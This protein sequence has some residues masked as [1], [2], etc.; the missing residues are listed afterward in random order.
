MYF[1]I[2]QTFSIS[3]I[4]LK[5]FRE[6]IVVGKI[7]SLII[8]L[9]LFINSTQSLYAERKSKSKHESKTQIS[10]VLEDIL[11]KK[12][13][14]D[15]KNASIKEGILSFSKQ[16]DIP[17]IFNNSFLKNKRIVAN[18]A[19]LKLT[20]MKLINALK[21]LLKSSNQCFK[22]KKKTIL[23]TT[24]Y[25]SQ[26]LFITLYSL[27]ELINISNKSME[28]WSK[29]ANKEGFDL[30][31]IK[32]LIQ[33][34]IAKDSWDTA[35]GTSIEILKNKLLIIH[36][37]DVHD[38]I[39]SFLES[40]LKV[41]KDSHENKINVK[42]RKSV[43]YSEEDKILEKKLDIKKSFNWKNE[44]L[45]KILADIQHSA[46]ISNFIIDQ[47]TIKNLGP[48]NISLKVSDLSL[49]HTLN[50]ALN[51]LSLNYSIAN[52]AIYIGNLHLLT[53]E[54]YNVRDI[55]VYEDTEDANGL[56]QD[57][58]KNL[59]ISKLNRSS[60]ENN[61]GT[62][63]YEF[64]GHLL[65]TQTLE[66]HQLIFKFIELFRKGKGSLPVENK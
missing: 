66:M 40:M 46:K 37:S 17:I 12:V 34:N 8:I 59:I 19:N 15:F 63:I 41:A 26:N 18:C 55:C 30:D 32:E 64:N 23:L 56:T 2:N 43:L 33:E 45:E 20:K 57:Y 31:N 60:W 36:N 52:G 39:N 54:Q 3:S 10:K 5:L 48:T 29:G 61:K 42:V 62:S 53:L 28:K 6:K 49:K 22:I 25:S 11:N 38:E 27:N 21:Y 14:F 7:I 44:T 24:K 58:L 65:I 1:K 50:I 47:N 9:T 16:A 13:S 35:Q 51:K 4:A